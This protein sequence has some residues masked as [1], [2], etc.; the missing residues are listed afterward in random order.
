M[1]SDDDDEIIGWKDTDDNWV[2]LVINNNL[3]PEVRVKKENLIISFIIPGEIECYDALNVELFQL[4]AHILAWTGDIPAVTKIM[5]FIG[6][7]S[8]QGCR[9]CVKEKSI[10]FELKS[11]K[12][13]KSFPLDIIMHLFFENVAKKDLQ[14]VG[15]I[16]Y[17]NKYNI[18]SNG[19]IPRN[20]YK[21]SAGY[22]AEEWSK[23]ILYFSLPLM[24]TAKLCTELQL[25]GDEPNLIKENLEIFIYII[26]SK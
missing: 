17:N 22:K 6:H 11:I 10:L 5:C 20:I 3:A 1:D 23:W 9:F 2:F 7:N 24:K 26:L 14:E 15:N 8:Y 25:E 18:P 13:P 12:F 4:K 19:R 21:H 16:L